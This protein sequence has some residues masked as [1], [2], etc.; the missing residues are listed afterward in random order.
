MNNAINPML[1][2][3]FYKTTHMRQFPHGTTQLTSYF[4][5]RMSRLKSC[6]SI[7][8][9]GIQSFCKEYLQ[10]YF[11]EN[12]FNRPAH[13]VVNEY[14]RILNYSLGYG[15]FN[16]GAILY[17]HSL[18]YLPVQINALPEGT[19]CPIHVPF[20]EMKNTHPDFAWVPQ[21]LESFMSSELWHPM[22]SAT[23]GT[24]YRDIVNR[25]YDKT[26]DDNVPRAK[27]L[28]DFSFR[29]QECMNSAVKSSAGWCLSFL[30]T[31]TVPAIPWLEKNYLCN[32]EI[33]PVAYGAVS[34]E[35]SVMCSNYAV[36]GSE[37]NFLRKL[38]YE[39]YPNDNFSVV[40]DSYDYWNLVNNILPELRE[41]I[42]NHNGT[43]LI[44]GDS[45]DPV[46]IVTNTVFKLWEI[47]GGT[48]NQKGY[49]VLNP[50]VKALY[51]DSITV[52]RCEKIFKILEDNGFA[53]NNV[54]LGVGSFSMQCI[55]EDGILK[56]FTR[57]TF[58]MAVKATHG[59]INEKEVQIFKNPKTDT[60][61]FKKS[62]KGLCSVY[63]DEN[64]VLQVQDGLYQSERNKRGSLLVPVFKDG[65]MLKQYTL[66]DVRQ[67]LWNGNF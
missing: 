11:N 18:G 63:K 7:V 16:E 50:H 17:L 61:N 49:K 12:F 43:M 5:P 59:V 44:R 33:E 29:G 13:E 9:F 40:S 52:Q 36:D 58:G 48:E 14:K 1:L 67:N 6:N 25:Y 3:D 19:R 26:V 10:D 27:A 8:V 34:T 55:E 54:S 15:L 35:H 23:V 20:L 39:L 66:N 41:D 37:K 4:T 53:A 38:L 47:F 45:G 62:L 28:G 46:D 22:I 60:A 2:C 32:C 57:D 51:G 56:P 64:G 65:H 42:L 21:F 24:L 30:N 31:A